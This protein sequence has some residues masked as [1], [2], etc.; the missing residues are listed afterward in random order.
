[1]DCAVLHPALHHKGLLSPGFFNCRALQL[2]LYLKTLRSVGLACCVC[3]ENCST[4]NPSVPS[5]GS[6]AYNLLMPPHATIHCCAVA[7]RSLGKST[8]VVFFTYRSGPDCITFV[9]HKRRS[10]WIWALGDPGCCALVQ[11]GELEDL[12]GR[13]SSVSGRILRRCGH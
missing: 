1:M 10:F 8:T 13:V 12:G 7:M 2:S 4:F 5:W 3:V 11:V 6:A 9:E